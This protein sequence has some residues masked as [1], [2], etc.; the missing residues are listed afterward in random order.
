MILGVRGSGTS[1]KRL[2][3]RG[4]PGTE[5]K[6]SERFSVSGYG[7]AS[8][9]RLEASL[10]AFSGLSPKRPQPPRRDEFLNSI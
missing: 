4:G 6:M 2:G 3:R 10:R 9:T 5:A 1:A 8:N 7:Y